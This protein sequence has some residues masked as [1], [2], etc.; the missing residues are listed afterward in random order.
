MPRL[1]PPTFVLILAL[2]VSTPVLGEEGGPDPARV[3]QWQAW[4]P[5]APQGVG[6]PITDRPAWEA[7]RAT[8]AFA[9]IPAQAEKLQRKPLPEASDELYQEYSRNGNRTSYQ[10]VMGPR[11]NRFSQLTLAE[12]LEDQGRFLPAIE[13]AI[14]AISRDKSWLMPAHDKELKTFDGREII[15]DLESAAVSWNLATAD[16]WLA[17]RLSPDARALIR[18]ELQ[19]RTFAPFEACVKTGRPAMSWLMGTSNWNAVCLAGVTGTAL[20]VIDDPQRRAWYAA[21]AEKYIQNFLSGFTPDGYCSEGVGYFNYGFGHFV[22]LSEALVQATQGKVDLFQEPR[23]E[24]IGRFGVRMEVLPGIFPAFAD[25]GLKTQPDPE[26]MAFL[27]RR[28]QWGLRNF[29]DAEW[30]SGKAPPALFRIGVLRFPNSAS[31]TPA[32]AASDAPQPLRDWFPDAGILIE[33]PNPQSRHGLGVGLKG[34]HNAE[35]HNHNDV[36]SY[37]I[38]LGESTPLVDPGSEI[39]T[40]RTF[41]GNRYQS[42]V[43]NS[44]GHPVPRV[45]GQLQRQGRD[46]Q[47]KVLATEFTDTKDTI[48]FDLRSAYAVDSLEELVRTFVFSREE[49]G[50]L[51]VTDQ[52]RF[53]RPETFGTALVTFSPWKQSDGKL[54]VGTDADQVEVE[55]TTGGPAWKLQAEEIHEDLPEKRIPTRL[56][57]ELEEPVRAAT[58]QITIRPVRP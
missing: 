10:A 2:L 40:K 54:R 37:M 21:A 20:A 36:G 7:L 46:A 14:R 57:I 35:H 18:T 13:E 9:K 27:S 19:R 8:P 58:I 45:A 52:V 28:Y 43:L 42:G 12:C 41:S 11:H 3:A 39:Y 44:F 32:A 26:L 31:A 55:I 16:Y 50:S 24:T 51:T 38:A 48:S 30:P 6:R 33:R 15:I 4:L 56:G 25:C 22:F 17:D 1:L 5:A 34:G 53:A 49:E 29:E 47:G 23:V